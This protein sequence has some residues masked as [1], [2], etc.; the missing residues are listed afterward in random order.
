YSYITMILLFFVFY[1]SSSSEFYSLSLHDALPIFHRS[2]GSGR[3]GLRR[4]PGRRADPGLRRRRG[5]AVGD[6]GG[7][8][9]AAPGR[10][11]VAGGAG[12][13]AGGTPRT[14]GVWRGRADRHLRRPAPAPG[15]RLVRE[16]EPGRG[17]RA[18]L[19]RRRGSGGRDGK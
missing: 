19:G 15:R 8:L 13:D 12:A 11:R 17:D 9:L 7:R 16:V 14:S 6:L 5:K 3:A 10:V 1:D 18:P 2:L 4:T